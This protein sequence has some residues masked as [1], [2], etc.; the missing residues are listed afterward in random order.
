MTSA[1]K[2]SWLRTIRRLACASLCN[3]QVVALVVFSAV[4]P[5]AMSMESAGEIASICIAVVNTEA[6]PDG[7]LHFKPTFD[8]GRCWGTF[9]A[10]QALS[11][12]KSVADRPPLLGIC[13]PADTTRRDLVKI[14]IDYVNSHPESRTQDFS[15]VAIIALRSQYPCRNSG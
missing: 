12:I 9:A 15:V 7:E 10:V 5:K 13:A 1:G 3:V 11:R 14:F 4:A 2:G 6:G 8:S